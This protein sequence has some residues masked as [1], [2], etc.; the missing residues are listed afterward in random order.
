MFSECISLINLN[1]SNFITSSVENFNYM[2]SGCSSLISLD[3]SN[4]DT[5]SS[6]NITGMFSG[7]PNL[8]NINLKNV[9]ISELTNITSLF[10]HE[11]KNLILCMND[12]NSLKRIIS[13]TDIN[14]KTVDCSSDWGIYKNNISNENN[15]LCI[16]QLI[17]S[18]V[19]KEDDICY[20]ICSF[21]IFYEQSQNK[22]ICT[23][24]AT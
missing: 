21:Y 18:K 16:N 23:E 12:S 22:Y 24:N 4:F 14:N 3:F 8:K 6:R 2:F 7:C 5:S 1:I 11:S 15:N 20:Q 10:S 13:A 19:M 17:L 9:K